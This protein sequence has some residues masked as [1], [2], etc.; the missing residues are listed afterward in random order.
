[1]G[2][3]SLWPFPSQERSHRHSFLSAHSHPSSHARLPSYS[4]PPAH[5]HSHSHCKPLNVDVDIK[6]HENGD[7]EVSYWPAGRNNSPPST[8]IPQHILDDVFSTSEDKGKAENYSWS[9]CYGTFLGVHRGGHPPRYSSGSRSVVSQSQY[10]SNHGSYRES[11]EGSRGGSHHSSHAKSQHGSQH[12]SHHGSQHE[13]RHGSQHGSH[14]GSQHGSHHGSQHG[15]QHGSHHQIQHGNQ[16][17]SRASS[18]TRTA[19]SGLGLSG[20]HNKHGFLST[21]TPSQAGSVKSHAVSEAHGSSG[22]KSSGGLKTIP[23]GAVEIGSHPGV[24]QNPSSAAPGSRGA[25][26]P[27]HSVRSERNK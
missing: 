16:D 17:R 21:R 23:E 6:Q 12:E 15:S 24:H 8:D 18:H 19:T 13:S 20:V 4:H 27:G 22:L 9:G 7:M 10:E 1:M 2:L 11:H 5:S 26:T 14:H 25:G 3:K